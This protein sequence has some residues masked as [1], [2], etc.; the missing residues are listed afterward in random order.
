M[1]MAITAATV[2]MTATTIAIE[3]HEES[4]CAGS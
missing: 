4:V 3:G 2:T 1:V